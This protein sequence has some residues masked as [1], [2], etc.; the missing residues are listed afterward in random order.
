MQVLM[1][2]Q[3]NEVNIQLLINVIFVATAVNAVFIIQVRLSFLH[4]GLPA[5][6]D[7]PATPGWAGEVL[8]RSIP[9]CTYRNFDFFRMF[10]EGS[11][12]FFAI[13]IRSR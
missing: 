7:S 9:T 3:S 2:T 8:H 10:N 6:A 1:S 11:F 5:A 12:K 13:R 4:L